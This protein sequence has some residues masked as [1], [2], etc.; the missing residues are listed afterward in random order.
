MPHLLNFLKGERH[1]LHERPH[2]PDLA[3]G[4][5]HPH[6]RYR[7]S[8]RTGRVRRSR[9]A[10]TTTPRDGK[11]PTFDELVQVLDEPRSDADAGDTLAEHDHRTA[12]KNDART[13]GAV[14]A[15]RLRRRRRRHREH[16]AR[17]RIDRRD[18][19]HHEGVRPGSPECERGRRANS[20][21]GADR[22]RRHRDPL[23]AGRC[24]EQ[25]AAASNHDV[26]TAGPASRTSPA[27]T[28]ATRRCS[29]R[30][31]STRRITNGG[32]GVRSNDTE[33][34]RPDHRSGRL[35]AASRAS[36]GCSRRTRSATS[37]QM[38]ESGMPVTYGYI[39][40]VHDLHVPTRR[41]TRTG[42]ARRPGR[43]CTIASSCRA[44][45]TR[46]RRSSSDLRRG[47]DHAG[48][49]TLFVDHAST[50]TTTSPA[51][52][53]TPTSAGAGTARRTSTIARARI[54][55]TLPDEPDR[56]GRR[57]HQG[58]ASPTGE[59]RHAVRRPLAHDAPV[60]L[61]ARA[62]GSA[63]RRRVRSSNG[64]SAA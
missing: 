13:V 8:I 28:P 58:H 4:G 3:H 22:L 64:T 2:D 54:S 63:R 50:R 24:D 14:H 10:T 5:R 49:N 35:P 16:R 37:R 18:R 40:D 36:T 33:R 61:R 21:H 55:T 44:T 46:S 26:A 19:R 17:E 27:A 41:A 48:S 6:D 39:S 47:R 52:R 7:V 31:T 51:A 29:A 23:R 45:T 53:R 57:E 60:D 59:R 25:R 9:T 15:R 56:R 34:R 38:Q 42:H 30:S 62:A 32:N 11:A 1:A 20:Q 12:Q 43:G